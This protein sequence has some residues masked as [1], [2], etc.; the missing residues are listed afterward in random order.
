[1]V[2]VIIPTYKAKDVLPHALDSLVAQTKR[3]FIVCISI[4]GDDE[5]YS[6]IIE[7]YKRRGLK[8]CV[9]RIMI[10]FNCFSF[11]YLR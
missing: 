8:I 4:D 3:M 9:I 2:G 7:E 6:E 5:D 11:I 1:M 10:T